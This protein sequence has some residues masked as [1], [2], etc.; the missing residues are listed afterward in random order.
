MTSPW[1]YL[2]ANKADYAWI[3]Q[4]W[5]YDGVLWTE[6]NVSYFAKVAMRQGVN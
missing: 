5:L 1:P 4:R 6:Y 3:W 2:L